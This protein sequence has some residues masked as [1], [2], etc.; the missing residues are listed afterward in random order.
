MGAFRHQGCLLCASTRCRLSLLLFLLKSLHLRLLA[1]EDRA[2]I[3]LN[4]A[5][6]TL[7]FGL[8]LLRLR[9]HLRFF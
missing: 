5:C 7:G 2:K 1:G 3:F 6:E 8:Q 9:S 4:H